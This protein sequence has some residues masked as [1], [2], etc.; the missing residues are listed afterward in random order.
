MTLDIISSL[1]FLD[2]DPRY[3]HEK[4]YE[5]IA[6]MAPSGWRSNCKFSSVPGLLIRDCRPFR[7]EFTIDKCGF[8]YHDWDCTAHLCY[9]KFDSADGGD[10]SALIE[11]YLLETI[12]RVRER[13]RAEKVVCFDWRLRSRK[14]KL[15]EQLEPTLDK[16]RDHAIEVA[17]IVHYDNSQREGKRLFDRCMSPSEKSQYL[18]PGWRVRIVNVWR[19]INNVVLDCPLAFCDPR[20][21]K[22]E[23]I[24]PVDKVHKD[25]VSEGCYLTHDSSQEWFFLS[26]Q[27]RNEAAL[28]VTWDNNETNGCGMI[29]PHGAFLDRNIPDGIEPRASIEAR[30][31]V[32]T[33]EP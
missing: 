11:P 25:H 4:P 30:L 3:Q 1:S 7:D 12:S 33:K 2:N 14:S 32:V 9:D 24:V 13:F 18:A 27:T 28:F 17:H 16:V 23:D 5:I 15:A 21:V 29:P 10:L 8:E 31:I 19:P 26:R 20:S 22:P 6:G